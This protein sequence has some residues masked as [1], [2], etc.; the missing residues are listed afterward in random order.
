[1]TWYEV[2]NWARPGG[3]CR[4]NLGYWHDD[5]WWGIGPGAH[6]HVGGT[7][8]VERQAPAHLRASAGRRRV[9]P[10]AGSR[11]AHRSEQRHTERVMLGLRL[12]E[13]LPVDAL[14]AASV[15]RAEQY[16]VEGLLDG[17]LLSAGR[18]VL[19][20]RGRLL[21]DAVVRTLII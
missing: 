3:E 14:D 2:S 15:P 8:L 10:Q 20:D 21:A 13:G 11:G 12:A 17:Q 16:A 1:M 4:H 7:P 5:D 9:D 19:T 6:S 18:L